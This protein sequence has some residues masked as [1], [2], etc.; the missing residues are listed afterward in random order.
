MH[1][2]N[3]N[4]AQI[5]LTHYVSIVRHG[6]VTRAPLSVKS[7]AKLSKH[8]FYLRHTRKGTVTSGPTSAL[9]AK[10]DSAG[11]LD[12]GTT[13]SVTPTSCLSAVSTVPIAPS[14]SFKW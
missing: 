12:F 14:K 4:T 6:I 3:V 2:R 11:Q 13:S 1:V 10:E 8:A 5:V 9:S 7:V